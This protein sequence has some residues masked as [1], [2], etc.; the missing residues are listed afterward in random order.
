MS[1]A[2][3]ALPKVDG[4]FYHISATISEEDRAP[5]IYGDRGRSYHQ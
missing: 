4:D 1:T 5:H 2:Q 3:K